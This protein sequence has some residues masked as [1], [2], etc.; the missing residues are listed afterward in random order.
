MTKT[1][2]AGELQSELLHSFSFSCVAVTVVVVLVLS[3]VPV[4]VRLSPV[5]LAGGLGGGDEFMLR[6]VFE[7]ELQFKGK[8]CDQGE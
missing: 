5:T 2:F 7:L 4:P 1:G 8:N 3:P 6:I